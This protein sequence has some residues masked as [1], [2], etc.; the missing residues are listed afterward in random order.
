MAW[1]LGLGALGG[2]WWALSSTDEYVSEKMKPV[3]DYFEKSKNDELQRK[4]E[5]DRQE[6]I[7]DMKSKKVFHDELRTKYNIKGSG[8]IHLCNNTN[9]VCHVIYVNHYY[10]KNKDE[11]IAWAKKVVVVDYFELGLSN[12]LNTKKECIGVN[13][14][15]QMIEREFVDYYIILCLDNKFMVVDLPKEKEIKI[16]DLFEVK[17]DVDLQCKWF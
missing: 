9:D 2:G 14:K 3:Y 12:K 4:V 16:S 11:A 8:F 1:L 7:N 17:H 15:L 5:T 13:C 10:G 6:S